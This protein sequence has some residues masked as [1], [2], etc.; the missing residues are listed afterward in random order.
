MSEQQ[1]YLLYSTGAAAKASDS[2]DYVQYSAYTAAFATD[3]KS[4]A[5]SVTAAEPVTSEA[6]I[7]E[8]TQRNQ[9]VVSE[10]KSK[11]QDWDTLYQSLLDGTQAENW[12]LDVNL[13][14]LQSSNARRLTL[15]PKPRPH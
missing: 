9:R 10:L 15:Q 7:A 12:L 8:I 6:T 5:A 13:F 4:S 11:S 2:L 3:S 1:G 14:L